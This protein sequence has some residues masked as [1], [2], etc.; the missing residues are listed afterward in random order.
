MQM[1]CGLLGTNHSENLLFIVM[2]LTIEVELVASLTD[3]VKAG[4]GNGVMLSKKKA[5]NEGGKD[6]KCYSNLFHDNL[7]NKHS[8][9]DLVSGHRA[10]DTQRCPLG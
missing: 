2:N 6:E 7:L 3:A 10:V 9:R 1:G 8:R 5:T 4:M